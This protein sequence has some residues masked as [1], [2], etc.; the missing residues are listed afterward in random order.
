MI[1]EDKYRHA[2]YALHV[3]FVSVRNNAAMS[4]DKRMS[5][6]FD[7]L[8]IIPDYILDEADKTENIRGLIKDLVDLYP[9]C[10]HALEV[11]DQETPPVF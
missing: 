11:L 1:R 3:F 9:D 10:S 8:E 2:L 6:A 5:I 7:Y 4:G